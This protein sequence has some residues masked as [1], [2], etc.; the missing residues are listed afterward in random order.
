MRIYPF[1][2]YTQPRFYDTVCG[3]NDTSAPYQA[4][5][6][7][8][9]KVTVEAFPTGSDS[10]GMRGF[11]G[12]GNFGSSQTGA[13]SLAEM[14]ARGDY[15]VKPIGYW[16]GG[17]DYVKVSK[18]ID[19]KRLFGIKDMKDDEDTAAAYN[20]SPVK[21]GRVCITYIP[22]DETST[23]TLQA[24]IRIRYYVQFFQRNDVSNS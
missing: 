11:L 10:T 8:A 9:C 15:V 23:R 3:A 18:Y 14:R 16:S 21:A 4:Y 13:S 12:I 24:L 20:A 19:I 22:A 2:I 1:W 7:F 6:V 17:H 5:R